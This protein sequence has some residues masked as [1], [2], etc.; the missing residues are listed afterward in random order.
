MNETESF[1]YENMQKLFYGLNI[2]IKTEHMVDENTSNDRLDYFFNELREKIKE[3]KGGNL[4]I[5]LKTLKQYI[6]NAVN[7][8]TPK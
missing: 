7:N 1:L 6:N 3:Q 2:G 5:P 8:I 4:I